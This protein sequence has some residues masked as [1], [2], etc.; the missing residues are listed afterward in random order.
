V[1][2]AQ[3][4][5]RQ[6]SLQLNP[7][8]LGPLN[9]EIKVSEQL[10]QM[11]MSSNHAQVRTALEQALPQ[12]RDALMEQGISLGETSISDQQPKQRESF[13]NNSGRQH[14]ANTAQNLPAAADITESGPAQTDSLQ[15][16]NLYV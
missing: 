15:G 9:I 5:E 13:S 16:I 1:T 3:N 6:I 10:A 4:G 11:H 14:S 8:D 2:L 7:Q 12:L